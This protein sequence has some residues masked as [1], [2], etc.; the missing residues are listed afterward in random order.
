[1]AELLEVK[2]KIVQICKE[3]TSFMKKI[4]FYRLPKETRKIYLYFSP[5]AVQGFFY[6]LSAT[7]NQKYKNIY[8]Y[9]ILLRIQAAEK[10]ISRTPQKK[11][12]VT[13]EKKIDYSVFENYG[14]QLAQKQ[15]IAELPVFDQ[16]KPIPCEISKKSVN[17]K[18]II[19]DHPFPEICE[20]KTNTFFLT[21]VNEEK[22]R[23]IEKKVEITQGSDFE[24]LSEE[25]LV[26]L[27]ES[28]EEPVDLD[29]KSEEPINLDES[30]EDLY[31]YGPKENS[32]NIIEVLEKNINE[33]DK[34][35]EEKEIRDFLMN[36]HKLTPENEY[37]VNKIKDLILKRVAE[38]SVKDNYF[39]FFYFIE[40]IRKCF[41]K[42]KDQMIPHMLK[43]LKFAEL[44]ERT[45]FHV[46]EPVKDF[47]VQLKEKKE[48]KVYPDVIQKESFQASSMKLKEIKEQG[49]AVEN[50]NKTRVVIELPKQ[51]AL[52]NELPLKLP[53]HEVN[54]GKCRFFC[55]LDDKHEQLTKEEFFQL[56]STIK[57]KFPK[58][59]NSY[60]RISNHPDL[61][62]NFYTSFT[63]AD[64]N[65]CHIV[66]EIIFYDY[67]TDL[68]NYY[69]LKD[70][71]E[72][73]GFWKLFIRECNEEFKTKAFDLIDLAPYKQ[74]C[75]LRVP[76]SKN[77]KGFSLIPNFTYNYY[78]IVDNQITKTKS[79]EK[80]KFE[81][82]LI[83][84][85][86]GFYSFDLYKVTDVKPRE[87]LKYEKL[88]FKQVLKYATVS[89]KH[90]MEWRSAAFR[91][92]SFYHFKTAE[93]REQIIV[94]FFISKGFNTEE[95]IK[96]NR[97]LCKAFEQTYAMPYKFD[98]L[99]DFFKPELQGEKINTNRINYGEF[100]KPT[101]R[102]V[103]LKSGT[104]TGKTYGFLEQYMAKG[105]VLV[106]TYRRSLAREIC[107]TVKDINDKFKE[108]NVNQESPYN[109]IYYQ[110]YKKQS[111]KFNLVCQLE[112]ICKFKDQLSQFDYVFLDEIE[113]LCGQF[114]NFIKTDKKQNMDKMISTF[115]YIMSKK[116]VFMVSG[117]ISDETINFLDVFK[118]PFAFY[119][120]EFKD[121]SD[122]SYTLLEKK[123]WQNRLLIY[124]EHGK[125]TITAI[126]S[127]TLAEDLKLKLDKF[128]Q[129]LLITAGCVEVIE[130]EKEDQTDNENN[131]YRTE[132]EIME[133]IKQKK[134]G[135]SLP[136]KYWVFYDHVI[137]SPKI[138]A[139]VNFTI[140]NHFDN[141][142]GYFIPGSNNF[143]ACY[144]M[145]FRCRNPKSKEVF[146]FIK[147]GSEDIGPK[148]EP[149]DYFD[150]HSKKYDLLR[151]Y[152]YLLANA[153][154]ILE[155]V[156]AYKIIIKET[157]F[158]KLTEL[159]LNNN[160]DI[161]FSEEYK[162]IEEEIYNLFT[163]QNVVRPDLNSI[164]TKMT[165]KI[166]GISFLTRIKEF[167]EEYFY[168]F[169]EY[170]ET[171][172][173]KKIRHTSVLKNK[174]EDFYNIIQYLNLDYLS[175]NEKKAFTDDL[176]DLKYG[177]NITRIIKYNHFCN[178]YSSMFLKT[179]LTKELEKTGMTQNKFDRLDLFNY[180]ESEHTTINNL[181]TKAFLC[182]VSSIEISACEVKEQKNT[183]RGLYNYYNL[184]SDLEK[185]DYVCVKKITKEPEYGIYNF[186]MGSE[187][188]IVS[189][190]Y[191][192]SLYI[193][194]DNKFHTKDYKES[195]KYDQ[196]KLVVQQYLTAEGECIKNELT[197][198]ISYLPLT[199]HSEF[200]KTC[201]TTKDIRKKI[202]HI[203]N[204][205]FIK[206][207]M[208]GELKSNIYGQLIVCKIIELFE[209]YN[210]NN[211]ENILDQIIKNHYTSLH[212]TF[213]PG[214]R[215]YKI[216]ELLKTKKFTKTRIIN[217]CINK[218]LFN[219]SFENGLEEL[220]KK[221]EY[222]DLTKFVDFE[223]EINS[224]VSETEKMVN[225]MIAYSD[226]LVRDKKKILGEIKAN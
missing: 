5:K 187:K 77:I 207:Y 165:N 1:M 143:K 100:V 101:D 23:F 178:I 107:S 24:V 154:N 25:E 110:D 80:V 170:Q 38:R 109:I 95:Y 167:L 175:M 145:L 155:E 151:S 59:V 71:S 60:F 217:S 32:S 136:P 131:I 91:I 74:T 19:V 138:E 40:S 156:E 150:Q 128:G 142:F 66:F 15:I 163:K 48:R 169:W 122:W 85:P 184:C 65:S 44:S 162:K 185:S 119:E 210:K 96:E 4:S 129:V 52:I 78:E 181:A 134:E 192:D 86:E 56:V 102:I 164:R 62:F 224:S 108:N 222:A 83:Y 30:F 148:D 194:C 35:I 218:A 125:K 149:D 114:K 67:K 92:W 177:D 180:Y 147:Q 98:T 188:Q 7:S 90:Y 215:K 20:P 213:C 223:K 33:L 112:S 73:K 157:E 54:R 202:N 11:S 10:V 49:F 75:Q 31:D 8:L 14:K 34:K 51:K 104:C 45:T 166:D 135:Y 206:K 182:P 16:I 174:S 153:K 46:N 132:D 99:N 124:A 82:M 121:K 9:T 195:V 216:N 53:V 212:L 171:P 133:L 200:I 144:Q 137:Y 126:N 127:K 159:I 97:E 106:I 79:A 17:S 158:K 87:Y 93:K 198:N 123:H 81:D 225:D 189:K 118:Q 57:N 141:I 168:E 88:R 161:Y 43:Y 111:G 193:F 220:H 61:Y 190:Y 172:G 120:N 50:K 42:L 226:M 29:E 12:R 37:E 84:S 69:A 152:T 64:Y 201:E 203:K 2:R 76:F 146:L 89:V 183:K 22:N 115:N 204:Y 219:I 209:N 18:C 21:Q 214:N 199:N 113:N 208:N 197:L 211:Y 176:F 28:S 68:P 160:E 130:K 105:S 72:Q 221:E 6:K 39:T 173:N 13:R 117:N 3:S 36:P 58:K 191:L 196:S 103:V 27:D 63:N 179:L 41:P 116:N 47:F 94:D 186:K 26:N 55:D 205:Y 140:P 70:A 139:G